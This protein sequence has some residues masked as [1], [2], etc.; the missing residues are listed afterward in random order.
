MWTMPVTLP[1]GSLE[2]KRHLN[3][4]RCGKRE[5]VKG[6]VTYDEMC[7]HCAQRLTATATPNIKYT[8]P[9]LDPN[10]IIFHGMTGWT[11]RNQIIGLGAIFQSKILLLII[12]RMLATPHITTFRHRL[13]YYHR[14]GQGTVLRPVLTDE[15]QP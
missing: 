6:G 15:D 3:N 14:S 13:S 7:N 5:F 11:I 10:V 4:R 1:L 8:T 2:M 9:W 12:R